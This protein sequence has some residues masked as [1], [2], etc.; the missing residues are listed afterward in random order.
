[1]CRGVRRPID[2]G[3]VVAGVFSCSVIESM[4][5]QL[6]FVSA[7]ARSTEHV[8]VTR[9]VLFWR[10]FDVEVQ[11]RVEMSMDARQKYR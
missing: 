4:S 1:M 9:L 2:A 11:M 3:I 5:G 8:W 6:S 7:E 10:G